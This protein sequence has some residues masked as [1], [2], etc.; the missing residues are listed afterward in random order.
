MFNE[1]LTGKASLD[2][3]T[4]STDPFRTPGEV[5]TIQCNSCNQHFPANQAVF[6]H[7]RDCTRAAREPLA[8]LAAQEQSARQFAE[9]R[10]HEEHLQRNAWILRA[11]VMVILAIGLAVFR[12]GMRS[13]MQEDARRMH[14]ESLYEIQNQ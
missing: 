10:A 14:G 4:K 5:A 11:V 13:Q 6:G 1:I 2:P 12:F 9:V 3:S 8:V 7:C